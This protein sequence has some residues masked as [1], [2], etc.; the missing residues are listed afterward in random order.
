MIV[1]TT[2]TFGGQIM[3]PPAV[4]NRAFWDVE[5]S[6][7]GVGADAVVDADRH[8]HAWCLLPPL[9]K[10]VGMTGKNDVYF[11]ILDIDDHRNGAIPSYKKSSP[12]KNPDTFLF[13]LT[14]NIEPYL[15]LLNVDDPQ[16]R[17]IPSCTDPKIAFLYKGE[18]RCRSCT[19][20]WHNMCQ[21]A[22]AGGAD[23]PRTWRGHTSHFCLCW[24]G[25]GA[26]VARTVPVTPGAVPSS[27]LPLHRRAM[28]GSLA[29]GRRRGRVGMAVRPRPT[30]INIQIP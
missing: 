10:K 8:P 20:G 21:G 5:L 25:R 6:T 24:C 16:N 22:Q 15:L 23:V 18:G 12:R 30:T 9:Y 13:F 4:E 11:L 1:S 28:L 17:A 7:F 14:V 19:A 26:D 27:G 3:T 29:A 2:V